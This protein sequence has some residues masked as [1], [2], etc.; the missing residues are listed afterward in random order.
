MGPAAAPP[1]VAGAAGPAEVLDGS[2]AVRV[3][4]DGVIVGYLPAQL[5]KEYRQRLAD[6]GHPQARGVCKARISAR[7]GMDYI[8]Y[9]VRLDLPSRNSKV[10]GQA[11]ASA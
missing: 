8:D 11:S 5:A 3:E 10:G 7:S 1:A 2:E 6:A 9:A 4:V